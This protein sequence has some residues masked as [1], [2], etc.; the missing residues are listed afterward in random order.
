M[1]NSLH[2]QLLKAGLV[3]EK[4][5][6]KAHKAKR[7]QVN[8]NR[9]AGNQ[10]VDQEKLKAQQAQERGRAR[11]RELNRLRDE[12]MQR[13]AITAQIRQLIGMNRQTMDEG[14]LPYN[15][16]DNGKIRKIHLTPDLHGQLSRGRLA[17][18][19]L[20]DRYE[21]V[22]AAVAD[23]I[24]LRDESYIILCN[25]QEQSDDEDDAYADYQVPD[26]LIW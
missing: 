3:D 23:K 13:K 4:R 17:I 5:V 8:Q 19:K 21:L 14:D 24:G 12:E 11:G 6:K 10:P 7:K 20:D 16:S 18:V 2:D 25:K 26:D 9:K 22:P 15:F 1:A